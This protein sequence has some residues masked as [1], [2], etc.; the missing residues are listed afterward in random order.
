[1][2]VCTKGREPNRSQANMG[3][4]TKQKPHKQFTQMAA[5]SEKGPAT[6]SNLTEPS[7]DVEQVQAEKSITAVAYS[8]LRKKPTAYLMT[9]K[10]A[11]A[12]PKEPN[13][14]IPAFVLFFLP[15]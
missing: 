11:I 15:F 4:E 12:S 5:T 8:H 9:R 13:K 6:G 3:Q 2:L 14:E 1:M 10:I 7:G